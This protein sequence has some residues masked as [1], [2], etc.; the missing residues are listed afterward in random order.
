M[1]NRRLRNAKRKATLE[2]DQL[3]LTY[4]RNKKKKMKKNQSLK[5]HHQEYQHTYSES[6]K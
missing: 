3:R 6:F 4:L 5:V 2:D 1:L